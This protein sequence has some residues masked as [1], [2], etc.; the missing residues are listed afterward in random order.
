MTL[1]DLRKLADRATPGPWH[2]QDGCSWR[3]IGTRWGDGDVICP[4]TQ[5]VD[6]HPDLHAK[7]DDLEYIAACYP[8]IILSLIEVAESAKAVSVMLPLSYSDDRVKQFDSALARLS[9]LLEGKE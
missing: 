1:S 8:A 5:R 3:R 4:I 2:V 7:R 9:S 6:N